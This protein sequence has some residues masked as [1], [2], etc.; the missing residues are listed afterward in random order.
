[1]IFRI[2]RRQVYNNRE[3]RRWDGRWKARQ[4]RGFID[5]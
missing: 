5:T 2:R 3:A 1:M 4:S